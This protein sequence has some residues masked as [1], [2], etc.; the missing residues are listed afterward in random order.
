MLTWHCFYAN[1]GYVAGDRLETT[2]TLTSFGICERIEANQKGRG[3]G[4]YASRG[5]FEQNEADA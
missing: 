2:Y 1:G 5:V 3:M 4:K